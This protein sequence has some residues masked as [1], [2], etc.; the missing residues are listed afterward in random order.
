MSKNISDEFDP[1]QVVVSF[2]SEADNADWFIET[3]SGIGLKFD[4]C[5]VG[6]DNFSHGNRIRALR[7]RVLEAYDSLSPE[8]KL[9]AANAVIGRFLARIQRVQQVPHFHGFSERMLGVFQKIGWG[10][11]DDRLVTLEPQIREM[12]FPKDSQWDAFVVIRGIIEKAKSEL[13]VV[14]PFCDREIFAILQSSTERP[15]LVRL[16]CRNKPDDLKAEAKKFCEQHSEMRIEV[17]TSSDF[18]D[19][20]LVVDQATCIHIGASINHAGSRAF[21]ISAV[22]DKSN[23]DALIKVVSE[24][25]RTGVPV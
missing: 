22:E 9:A 15:K 7:P 2:A 8:A 11:Q 16:L 14:D 18:H 13:M 20:F 5:L 6:D 19:R 1:F 21:M 17:R 24:A 3:F 4:I 12:F 10:F 25:W 23:R